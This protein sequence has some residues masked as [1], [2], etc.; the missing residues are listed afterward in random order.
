MRPKLFTAILLFI[1]S[2][3]PLFLILV[4]KDFDF[5]K[6]QFSHPCLAFIS[7]LV[8]IGS[9]FMLFI[10]ISSIRR[11]NLIGEIITVRNRSVDLINYTIPYMISFCGIDLNKPEDL[12]SISLFMM[13]L[14]LLTITS[15]SVFLN[16]LL[17]IIGYGLYD[18][19]YK[20]DNK[21]YSVVVLSKIELHSI[22]RYYLR[23]LTRFLYIVVEKVNSND[24]VT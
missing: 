9:V 7:L 11:G 16:P 12:I 14:L 5:C 3:S 4:I 6:N 1:S 18:L 2:Y 15:K 10:T 24:N 23:S 8:I 13:I 20:L 22:E 21:I 17:A 19:E